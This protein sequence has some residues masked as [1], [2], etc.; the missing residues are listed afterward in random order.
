MQLVE[1][2]RD[3]DHWEQIR[4]TYKDK[5]LGKVGFQTAKCLCCCFHLHCVCVLVLCTYTSND[6][7]ILLSS[8]VVDIHK[9]WCGPC[10][11]MEPAYKRIFGETDNADKRVAFLTVFQKSKSLQNL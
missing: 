3:V 1:N 9:E 6:F 11:I 7:N 8:L 2:V 10:K 4:D 5:L